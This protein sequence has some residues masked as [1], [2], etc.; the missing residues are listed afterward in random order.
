MQE[1]TLASV[2][3]TGKSVRTGEARSNTYS[4][5]PS[6]C[7]EGILNP[8]RVPEYLTAFDRFSFPLNFAVLFK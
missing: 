1:V 4:L 2:G 5:Y 7:G 3:Y 6:T 8:G